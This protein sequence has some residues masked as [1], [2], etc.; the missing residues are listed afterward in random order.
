MP[1]KDSNAQGIHGPGQGGR[2]SP[3]IWTAISRFLLQ[4]MRDIAVRPPTPTG[5]IRICRRYHPLVHNDGH[6]QQCRTG[7]RTDINASNAR[8]GTTLGAIAASH[9]R[10]IGIVKVLLLSH[11]MVVRSRRHSNLTFSQSALLHDN[12]T[13]Q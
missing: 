10:K 13:G 3:A 5:V 8:H 11:Y 1:Y 4:W 2:A 6:R 7:N 12:I 9:Q